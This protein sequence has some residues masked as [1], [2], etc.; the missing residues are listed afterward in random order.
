MDVTTTRK[1]DYQPSTPPIFS[2]GAEADMLYDYMTHGGTPV[3]TAI[4]D[5]AKPLYNTQITP[6][7]ITQYIIRIA[8]MGYGA[9]ALSA[10]TDRSIIQPMK[11]RGI[12][13]SVVSDKNGE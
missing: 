4:M 9:L 5:K 10:M 12:W 1:N 2:K 7:L 11:M 3:R 6:S 8:A 13:I